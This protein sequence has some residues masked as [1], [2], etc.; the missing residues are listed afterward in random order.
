VALSAGSDSHSGADRK[1]IAA[2]PRPRNCIPT[3]SPQR[4]CRT[5]P[6]LSP[7][8]PRTSSPPTAILGAGPSAA[9]ASSWIHSPPPINRPTTSWIADYLQRKGKVD[10]TRPLGWPVSSRARAVPGPCG[11]AQGADCLRGHGFV[12]ELAVYDCF[13]CH[14]STDKLRWTSEAWP[15]RTYLPERCGLQKATPGRPAGGRGGNGRSGRSQSALPDETNTLV[16]AGQTD[17]RR[18]APTACGSL[19]GVAAGSGRIGHN[20]T[21]TP[22]AGPQ[23]IRR[24]LLQYAASGP[25]PATT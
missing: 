23:A 10:E 11:R 19:F 22:R 6:L 18:G 12:P 7:G 17:G 25:C 9:A 15:G 2:N 16:K 20:G 21:F 8:E 3:E 14:H 13:A 4:R 24:V 5:L 1:R